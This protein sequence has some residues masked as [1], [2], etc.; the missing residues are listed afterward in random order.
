MKLRKA[1]MA[2]AET[3]IGDVD[4]NFQQSCI[5]SWRLHASNCDRIYLYPVKLRRAANCCCLD[6]VD[7]LKI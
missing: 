7:I 6:D 4:M 5:G 3:V 2:S 1:G